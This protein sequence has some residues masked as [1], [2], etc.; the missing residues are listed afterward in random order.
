[1]NLS[2]AWLVVTIFLIAAGAIPVLV[3]K[4]APCRGALKRYQQRRAIRRLRR[5]L[6]KELRK[7]KE[8]LCAVWR[9][10]L[11]A[12]CASIFNGF[13]RPAKKADSSEELAGRVARALDTASSLFQE[14]FVSHYQDLYGKLLVVRT[15]EI[16]KA[17]ASEYPENAALVL[18]R[19]AQNDREILRC[20]NESIRE[21]LSQGQGD[22]ELIRAHLKHL[23]ENL[24]RFGR[25]LTPGFF[26]KYSKFLVGAGAGV[27]LRELGVESPWLEFKAGQFAARMWGNFK[28]KAEEEFGNSF[29]KV[30]TEELPALCEHMD[31]RV[32][33]S[34]SAAL[35][36]YIE[37]KFKYQRA[38]LDVLLDLSR[39]RKDV[40][41][42][43]CYFCQQAPVAEATGLGLEWFPLKATVATALPMTLPTTESGS[44]RIAR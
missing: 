29:V 34:L 9:G 41:S 33:E 12:Q 22:R 18:E 43:I 16:A 21:A 44:S 4:T 3:I 38:I 35:S 24:P 39:S 15:T 17:L 14:D 27:L 2:D 10:N 11:A 26:R 23:V 42:G 36:G 25:L 32:R 1:M 40:A 19:L 37:H 31:A 20:F 28:N 7:E 13:K 30:L 5:K 8:Q 6:P